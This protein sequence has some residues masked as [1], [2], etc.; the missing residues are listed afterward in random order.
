MAAL[1]CG[2]LV[3]PISAREA[4]SFAELSIEE[5]MNES[6]TSVSKRAQKLGDA[7][8]AITVLTHDDLTRSGATSIAESLRLVPGMDVAVGSASDWAISAR[9]FNGVFSNKLLMLV[10]GRAVYNPLFSGVF[11]DL[12]Q[13]MLEDVDRIEVIR[14][15][16]A[17]IWGANAVNGVINVV[18]RSASETQGGYLYG[19]GGDMHRSFAGARYGGKLGAKT[20]YR[21]FGS[22]Q[23]N[24]SFPQ[25]N[26]QPAGDAWQA[27]HG[28][29]RLD[30]YP[31][32][33]THLTWQADATATDLDDRIS[34]SSNVNTLVR[35]SRQ[36]SDRSSVEVQAYYDRT[37]RFRPYQFRIATDI[38]DLA[39]QHSFGLG[40]RHDITWGLGARFN[41][42]HIES[43]NFANA[44]RDER[45][46]LPLSSAFVQDEFKLVP[47][48]LTFTTGLKLEHNSYTGF[49]FQ[50]G[51]RA[52]FKP[53]ERQTLW[54]AASRAVRTPN[55]F[56]GTDMTAI[57]VG[58]PFPGPGGGLF[59]PAVVGNTQL[60]SEVLHA[61]ELGYRI[62]PVNRVSI[63]LAAFYN[64]YHGLVAFGGVNNLVPGVPFGVAEI[65]AMNLLDG[66]LFGGEAVVT[67]TPRDGWRIT[68]SYSLLRAHV[69]Q[70][71]IPNPAASE[72]SAP[73]NQAALRS[74]YDFSKRLSG[75]VQVRYVDTVQS[76]PAYVTA[77]VQFSFHLNE[78]LTLSVVGQNLLDKQHAEQGAQVSVLTS[79]APRNFH[80]KLQ[81]HF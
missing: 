39:A 79:E 41:V 76:V 4:R 1:L 64:T 11:W 63:D 50:P 70:P 8:A 55:A 33:D 17:T 22:Y 24:D 12:Q 15:P 43:T 30:S 36:I 74:S 38:V 25:A 62:Q 56:E 80:A 69:D 32:E 16:G 9:G 58:A 37:T 31:T 73:R 65:P 21:L 27:R 61:Y 10:D 42:N 7:A 23:T 47:D 68:A 2:M 66:H 72:R 81:W 78:Q 59:L 51:L 67:V 60:K 44:V 29:F 53:T 28:G 18:S 54:A 5:L 35:W 49:E 45:T 52:V 34:D 77:D 71:V 46:S 19:G 6:V 40:A 3:A 75:E 48:K 57:T 26:G 14:G 20:Y 13:S